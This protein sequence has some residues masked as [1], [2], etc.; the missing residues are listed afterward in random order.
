VDFVADTAEER[1]FLVVCAGGVG[2]VIE[3]PV[4]TVELA[5]KDGAAWSAL[6]QT[7]IT[8]STFV[9]RNSLRCLEWCC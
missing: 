1:E 8:V 9:L 3:A 2:G 7:V 4:M 5:G 6:P